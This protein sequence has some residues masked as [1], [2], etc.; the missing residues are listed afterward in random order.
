MR[1]KVLGTTLTASVTNTNKSKLVLLLLDSWPSDLGPRFT[2]RLW[3]RIPR[4]ALTLCCC[5]LVWYRE[6]WNHPFA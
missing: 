3:V 1:K 5:F 6:F 4:R 2:N